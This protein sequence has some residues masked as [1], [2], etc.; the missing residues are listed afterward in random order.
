MV[1]F[2]STNRSLQVFRL[3]NNG[4]GIWGGQVVSKAI[5]D[6]AEKV[7]KNGEIPELREISCGRNRLENGSAPNWATA[8]KSLPNLE[9]VRL[10]QNGIRMEGISALAIGLQSCP[11]L[12]TLDLQDNTATESGSKSISISIPYWTRLETL[13][14][15]DC[16]IGPRGGI[17]ISTALSLGHTPNLKVLK[18]QY[19]EFDARTLHI[20]AKAI[21]EH[22]KGLERLEINGN[23]ADPEGECVERVREALQGNGFDDALDECEFWASRCGCGCWMLDVGC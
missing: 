17:H 21:S 5:H 9:C 23:R 16:L 18:L 19:G 12:K 1:S 4:L 15:S 8:F 10:P 2:L 3:N 6:N 20:L 14:L 13:N 11:N 7:L 22:L